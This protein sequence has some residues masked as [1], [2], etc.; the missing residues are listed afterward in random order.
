MTVARLN[1]FTF[2]FFSWLPEKLPRYEIPGPLNMHRPTKASAIIPN[3]PNSAVMKYFRN[4]WPDLCGCPINS[5]CWSPPK[6][7]FE[8]P[9]LCLL[10]LAFVLCCRPFSFKFFYFILF[11]FNFFFFCMQLIVL[12][13]VLL[14]KNNPN[15]QRTAR[16]YRNILTISKIIQ[17]YSKTITTWT[18]V[19]E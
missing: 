10:F 7:L 9:L 8:N 14:I 17:C 5:V 1:S 18:W 11:F 19:L 13:K 15:H 2:F 6:L 3:L 4:N 12:L 16:A